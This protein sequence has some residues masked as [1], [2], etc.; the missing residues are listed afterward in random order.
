MKNEEKENRGTGLD[1]R[2]IESIEERIAMREPRRPKR[3]HKS[4]RGSWN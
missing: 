3:M 4:Q 2:R 1:G